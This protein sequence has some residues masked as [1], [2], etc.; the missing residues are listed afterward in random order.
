[1]PPPSAPAV[2]GVGWLQVVV[3]PWGEVSVDG[4]VVGT[5]PLDRFSVKAGP[6]QVS[7]R[8]PAYERVT[9]QVTVRPDETQRVVVDF[10][11]DGVRK[12]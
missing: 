7:A 11:K 3:R 8:H 2:E 5:T 10:P 1:V 6:H 12:E 4:K 9:L